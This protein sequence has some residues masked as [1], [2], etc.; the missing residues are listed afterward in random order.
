M[1]SASSSS[2]GL[3]SG[4][5]CLRIPRNRIAEAEEEEEEDLRLRSSMED[6]TA[7]IVLQRFFCSED[8][9]EALHGEWKEMHE[10]EEEEEEEEENGTATSAILLVLMA[11]GKE[12]GGSAWVGWWR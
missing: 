4:D 12:G 5:G 3:E 9:V 6:R 8:R 10:A 7:E 1:T 11:I 2:K